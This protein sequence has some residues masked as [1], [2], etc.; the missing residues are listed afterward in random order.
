LTRQPIQIQ[1]DISLPSLISSDMTLL[2]VIDCIGVGRTH[3][4]F[5]W[6]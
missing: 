4:Y 3:V 5:N 6:S 1:S 2:S